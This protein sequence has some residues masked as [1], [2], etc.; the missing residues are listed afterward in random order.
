MRHDVVAGAGL[1]LGG[2][3]ELVFFTLRRDVVDVNFDFVFLAPLVAEFVEGFIGAG[4]PVIPA[5]ECQL[6]CS[7]SASDIRSGDN[8]RCS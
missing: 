6:T 3:R 7:V 5:A 1:R 4:H 2:R 8:S